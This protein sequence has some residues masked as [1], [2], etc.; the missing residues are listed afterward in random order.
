MLRKK[1]GEAAARSC[2]PQFNSKF[3][4]AVSAKKLSELVLQV[5]LFN[6]DKFGRGVFLGVVHVP[7]EDLLTQNVEDWFPCKQRK[8]TDK[9]SKKKLR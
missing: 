5:S 1:V 2:D 8:P 4:F 6:L 9:V 7:L 3:S